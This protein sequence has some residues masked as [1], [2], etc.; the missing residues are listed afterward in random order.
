VRLLLDTATLLFALESPAR[1]SRQ[2]A[3][4]WQNPENALEVSAVSV[5][6][7]AIKAGKGKLNFSAL[8]LQR[9]LEEL[10]IRVL[11]YTA[12]HAFQLFDLPL[13]HRDPFDREIIAQALAEDIPVVTPDP[14]FSL[15]G[16]LRVVW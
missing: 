6:E 5:S 12:A 10:R 3:S 15:Y 14:K 8:T 16:G 1:L 13:H 9:A 4:A 2:A 11:P 7:I